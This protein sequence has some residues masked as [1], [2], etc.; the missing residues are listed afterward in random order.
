MHISCSVFLQHLQSVRKIFTSQY[1][2]FFQPP[3]IHPVVTI[4]PA[5]V[6]VVWTLCV[7]MP[8]GT[9]SCQELS[10]TCYKYTYPL[11][12]SSTIYS[13]ISKGKTFHGFRNCAANR[14]SF[15][16]NLFACKTVILYFTSKRECFPRE[17][18]YFN[19]EFLPLLKMFGTLNPYQ[20]GSLKSGTSVLSYDT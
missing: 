20:I 3:I 15:P 19:Y 11:S 7:Y 10:L 4:H 8:A 1:Q 5:V 16:H 14:E 12:T 6:V 17:L 2:A 13:K 18:Q 9:L